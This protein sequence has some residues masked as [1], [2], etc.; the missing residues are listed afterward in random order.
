VINALVYQSGRKGLAA[1]FPSDDV[2]VEGA[3]ID[4]KIA[5]LPLTREWRS[6][7]FSLEAVTQGFSK[8]TTLN[9]QAYSMAM[10]SRYLYVLGQYRVKDTARIRLI[11][12]HLSVGDT[13]ARF[14][15]INSAS[16]AKSL[17]RT[18]DQDRSIAF[19]C[20]NDDARVNE[21]ERISDVLHDWLSERF[22]GERMYWEK[23][24]LAVAVNAT[25]IV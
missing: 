15:T 16:Q 25:I 14:D 7:N 23:E 4:P 20:F 18:L 1:F 11:G 24:D 6:T 21:E 3:T 19:A 9:L 10:L 13:P 22:S 17:T 2:V 5:H 12:Y 8:P